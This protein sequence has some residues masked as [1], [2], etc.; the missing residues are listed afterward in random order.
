MSSTTSSS[1]GEEVWTP[2]F[3]EQEELETHC[4]EMVTSLFGTFNNFCDYVCLFDEDCVMEYVLTKPQF[5]AHCWFATEG[6]AKTLTG[7]RILHVIFPNND[8]CVIRDMIGLVGM[9]DT[10]GFYDYTYHRY[11]DDAVLKGVMSLVTFDGHTLWYHGAMFANSDLDVSYNGVIRFATSETD[12]TQMFLEPFS[13]GKL[14]TRWFAYEGHFEDGLF[15]GFGKITYHNGN[16]YQGLWTFGYKGCGSSTDVMSAEDYACMFRRGTN[17][18]LL[19]QKCECEDTHRESGGVWT[20]SKFI[21]RGSLML[22]QF[23]GYGNWMQNT[24]HYIGYFE[25]GQRHGDGK[26]SNSKGRVFDGVWD[27][28]VFLV[29]D[30]ARS[31]NRCIPS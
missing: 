24:T 3:N 2:R 30:N 17:V 15:H 8:H 29:P 4:R 19:K 10:N 20:T 26:E 16:S 11:A 18:D 27:H 5:R 21:Y 31:S 25:N 13:D 7:G 22:D 9:T 12:P 14:K 28:N 23:Y 6:R 1:D